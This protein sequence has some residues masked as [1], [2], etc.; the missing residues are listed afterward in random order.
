MTEQSKKVTKWYYFTYLERSSTIPIET[1]ICVEGNLPDVITY[2]KFQNEI[3][4]FTILQRVKFYVFLLIFAWALQR[5]IA[6]P[7]LAC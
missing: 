3:F 6:L 7:V 1:I 5:C 2:A 4:R